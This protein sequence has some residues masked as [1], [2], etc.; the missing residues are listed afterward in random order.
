MGVPVGVTE[1]KRVVHKMPPLMSNPE[2]NKNL[3]LYGLC[4][5]YTT[6]SQLQ[7]NGNN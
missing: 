6:S 4:R 7:F 1:Q 2:S 5:T 3:A